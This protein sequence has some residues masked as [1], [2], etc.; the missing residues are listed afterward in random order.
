MMN[1]TIEQS[2]NTILIEVEW[3]KTQLKEEVALDE[4]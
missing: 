4:H 2:L 1:K 3:I